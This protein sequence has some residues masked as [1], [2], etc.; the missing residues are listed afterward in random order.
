MWAVFELVI[1]PSDICI[2]P[3]ISI[4]TYH[5]KT[6]KSPSLVFY[7]RPRGG[8]LQ[9]MIFVPSEILWQI[10][11]PYFSIYFGIFPEMETLKDRFYMSIKQSGYLNIMRLREAWCFSMP[12]RVKYVLASIFFFFTAGTLWKA[13]TY[14][15]AWLLADIDHLP[16][17]ALVSCFLP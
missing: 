17:S 15:R 10:S 4:S 6:L 1:L 8:S 3:W 5:F 9:K 11:T 14:W 12:A 7:N 2:I 13:I 16:S